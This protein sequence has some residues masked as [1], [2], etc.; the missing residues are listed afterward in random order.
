MAGT[1]RE[2]AFWFQAKRS[3]STYENVDLTDF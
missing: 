1:A 3:G 2:D